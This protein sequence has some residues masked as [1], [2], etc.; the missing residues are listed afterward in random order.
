M[1]LELQESSGEGGW[2][3]T[4]YAKVENTFAVTG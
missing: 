4:S 2:S 3:S 1:R